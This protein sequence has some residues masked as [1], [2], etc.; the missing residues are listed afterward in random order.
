MDGV[1]H[2]RREAPLHALMLGVMVVAMASHSPLASIA[3]AA[4]LVVVSVPCAALSRTR[5]PFRAHVLDLWAMALALL[6]FLP[7]GVMTGQHHAVTVHSGWAFA[8]V[9]AAWLA[10]RV[11]LALREATARRVAFASGG[12]T[13]AGLVA[14]AAV[15]LTAM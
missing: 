4:L 11:W 5:T 8:A 3:G 6:L 15:C 1:A 14:M 9:G 10:A 2:L 13:A 12:M 7:Q